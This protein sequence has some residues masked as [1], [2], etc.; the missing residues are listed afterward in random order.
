MITEKK[1]N[2]KEKLFMALG[3]SVF[4]GLMALFI[5]SGDKLELLKKVFL[6][7]YNL[8]L[9][10][11]EFWIYLPAAVSLLLRHSAGEQTVP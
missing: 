8:T 11:K 7:R 5:F 3:L 10:E 4:V 6:A 2:G 1:G 9:M